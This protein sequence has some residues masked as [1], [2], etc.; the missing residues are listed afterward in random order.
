MSA[1]P[2]SLGVLTVLSVI[3]SSSLEATGLGFDL[4]PNST[5]YA[6]LV[7]N[8]W[9]CIFFAFNILILYK[10]VY[11]IKITVRVL[12]Q[13][14]IRFGL[15]TLR[16]SFTKNES[17]AVS[18]WGLRCSLQA[19]SQFHLFLFR[20]TPFLGSWPPAYLV[21]SLQKWTSRRI[22]TSVNYLKCVLPY[23]I[24]L[25]TLHTHPLTISMIFLV[26]EILVINVR[27]V[28]Q[29][30]SGWETI[31]YTQKPHREPL[32]SSPKHNTTQIV[33]C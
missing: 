24:S 3:C 4:R 5:T 18:L 2:A 26:I 9:S 22:Y 19:P 15:L 7:L 13:R 31:P 28:K 23:Y 6:Y 30:L 10:L 33:S 17:E 27:K 8:D 21:L 16:F 14:L 32:L 12:S 29:G 25:H 11:V 1:V 20:E